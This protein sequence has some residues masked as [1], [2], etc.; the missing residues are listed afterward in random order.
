[1]KRIAAL[2]A[3]ALALTLTVPA[4]AQCAMCKLNAESASET[5]DAGIGRGL[6]NGILYLMGIPYLLLG[7]GAFAFWRHRQLSAGTDTGASA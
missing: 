5:V 1:M 2:I 4:D 6:N 7:I 3:L